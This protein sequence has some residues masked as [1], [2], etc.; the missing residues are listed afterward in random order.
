M[1]YLKNKKILILGASGQI[2]LELID[3]LDNYDCKITAVR[4]S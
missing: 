1:N 4:Y 3:H 2:G